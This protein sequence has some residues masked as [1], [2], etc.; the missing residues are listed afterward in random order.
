[1][2][3][4]ERNK[5]SSPHNWLLHHYYIR[6]LKK[7]AVHLGG[8]ILDIGCGIKPFREIIESHCE[9]YI[10][11]E[12]PASL[13]GWQSVDV[14]G[15]ALVLPF[16][17]ESFDAAVSFS[18]MEH[19]PEPQIFL[20][21][22]FRVLKPGGRALLMTPLMW[23]E[24]EIP[25]DYYRY[26]RYGLRYLAEKAGFEVISI[27]PNGGYWSMAI[28]R[29]NYWLNRLGKGPWRYLL[30]PIWLNQYAALLLDK[31]DRAYTVDAATFTTLLKKP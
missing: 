6:S 25:H 19:V 29:F 31:I 2:G 16:R 18:V 30:M 22:A 7:H 26:T 24:H 27:E 23:G 12:H 21:E 9:K 1:M 15:D 28:L 20:S 5:N 4:I 17:N 10:G 11:L 13:H 14:A 8:R 3:M